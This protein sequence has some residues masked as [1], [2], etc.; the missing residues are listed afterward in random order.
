MIRTSLLLSL[1]VDTILI[2]VESEGLPE[3]FPKAGQLR[4]LCRCS[5]GSSRHPT[6]TE[7]CE[8][9]VKNI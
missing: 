6:R 9:I 5:R 2:L 3:W 1:F 8:S 4:C 7:W